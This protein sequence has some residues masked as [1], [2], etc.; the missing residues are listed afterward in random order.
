[1]RLR[2]R[3]SAGTHTLSGL[4][5]CATLGDLRKKI[6]EA[7]SAAAGAAFEIKFGF[8]PRTVAAGEDAGTTLA[9]LGIADGEAL[10]VREVEA[11]AASASIS[12]GK[13]DEVRA[14]AAAEPAGGAATVGGPGVAAPAAPA[15]GDGLSISLR[16][17]SQLVKRVIVSDNSC[18]F[19]S[20]GYVVAR[21]RDM[22]QELRHV[23]ARDVAADPATFSAAV[24]E[25]EPAEYCKW[26]L[27]PQRWGGQIE[28]Q[29]LA[30][31]FQ[32]EIAAFDIRTKRCDLYGQGMGYRERA[33][34]IYDG[35]HYDALALSA[36]GGA[37]E[38]LD[39]TL[40]EVST[41]LLQ[42]AQQAAEQLVSR[43]HQ[44]CPFVC[45]PSQVPLTSHPSPI[46]PSLCRPHFIQKPQQKSRKEPASKRGAGQS[47]EGKKSKIHR[48]DSLSDSLTR[49]VSLEQAK[50]FTDTHNFTLRCA[51]CQKGL[52]GEK[53]AQ[54]HAKA[55]GHVNFQEY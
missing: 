29:V 18:L 1:M 47:L 25:K 46:A 21:R 43:L 3:S 50:Q 13:K 32:K 49:S 15:E 53:E 54:E 11:G 28:L 10:Q 35:L 36:F 12:G 44:V 20:V 38:E 9:S 51:V 19:N 33:M 26:I 31:H 42:E 37:P 16:D 22:A 23:V 17:G 6:R 4:G 55:T 48:L 27:D 34:V 30:S 5:E 8:P 41:A 52:R 39:V 40:F 45:P 14:S 24:L 2:C 7:T